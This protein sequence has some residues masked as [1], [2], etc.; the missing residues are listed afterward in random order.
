MAKKKKP[1]EL[2]ADVIEALKVI[3]S[4]NDDQEGGGAESRAD[5]QAQQRTAGNVGR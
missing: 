2:G 5:V 1:F 4:I 3:V